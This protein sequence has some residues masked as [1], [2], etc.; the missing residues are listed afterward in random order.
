[1]KKLAFFFFPALLLSLSMVAQPSP[2]KLDT[3]L[4]AY[5]KLG[6][7]SGSVLVAQKGI[8]IFQKGEGYKDSKAAAT[9]DEHTIFQIG[10]V[11][12]QFTSAIILQLQE[13]HK[14]AVQDKLSK[15][16]PGYPQ[17]DQISIENLLTHT[18]GV[19]NY[20]NDAAFMTNH[21]TQ[22]MAR[23]SL[24]ALFR[25]KPL[26]F[27]PGEKF[28]YSNSGYILLGYL[29]EKITGK[30]YFQ[31]VS[32]N[33]FQPL[34]M[35]RSGFDFAGLKSADKATGYSSAAM[36]QPA[37]VVDS[38]VSFSAGAMYTTVGDLY[39]W[40]RGLYTGRIVS[41]ASLEKAFTPYKSGYG[42]GWSIDSA[43]GKRDL[44][45]GGSITGFTSFI[46]RVPETETCIILL[47]NH[48]STVLGKIAADINALL[49][50]KEYKIPE[51][52]KEI[53][54]D[55]AI[56]RQYVGEYELAPAFHVVVTLNSGKLEAQPT[57][58]GKAQLF[59]EREGLFFL[60]VVDAEVEF[61]EGADGKIEKMILHQNG[62]QMPGKK[63]R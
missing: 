6:S 5:H 42:Y 49:N 7:F 9:N 63:V 37:P 26:G 61:Q 23:D 50:N 3:L 32:E 19:Y 46:L 31:V 36:D 57:G 28:S 22:P 41:Q 52:K 33:I 13:Q 48:Q 56:L 54:L 51:E 1:M 10:S 59:A 17:G 8:V 11:T 15:Y 40:D 27:P 44:S 58:Q 29:I 35:D 20:T 45:H 25:N 4:A 39:K 12:K 30:P 60:K 16:L 47:D 38:S 18:S 24:L 55:S 53:T 2:G 21:T 14:L 62:M 34:H 43:Y